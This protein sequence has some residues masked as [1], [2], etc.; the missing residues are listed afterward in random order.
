MKKAA[1]WILFFIFL[2]LIISPV[3]AMPG[4]IDDILYGVL[5]IVIVAV[6]GSLR[7]KKDGAGAGRPPAVPPPP[8][9]I[10]EVKGE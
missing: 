10:P 7:K 2:A 9:E 8:K 1:L 6:L 5:D 4:P 3:D